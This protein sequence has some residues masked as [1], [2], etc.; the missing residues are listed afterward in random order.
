[1]IQAW[2]VGAHIDIGGSAAKDGLSLYPLQWMLDQS[3]RNGLVLE[4]DGSFGN[5]ARMEDPLHLTFPFGM[6]MKDSKDSWS[7]TASNKTQVWMQDLRKLHERDAPRYTVHLNAKRSTILPNGP[8]RPFTR[9]AN[10]NAKVPEVEL[11]GYCE[12]GMSAQQPWS[13]NRFLFQYFGASPHVL[14]LTNSAFL[15]CN[16][17]KSF[18]IQYNMPKQE[19][20]SP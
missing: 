8:R 6:P 15:C 19:H 20:F 14:S 9:E 5:R 10:S 18:K 4:F 16:V 12:Y 17:S 11:R 2:F 3:Y 7:F 1:M 13:V